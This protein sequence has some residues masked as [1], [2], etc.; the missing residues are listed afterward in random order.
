MKF[1]L[2]IQ[3][4]IQLFIISSSVVIY[5]AA[6]GYISLNARKMAYT[7]AIELTN[8]KVDRAAQQVKAILDAQFYS[9]QTLSHAFSIFEDYNNDEW[10][11]MIHEMYRKV[12]QNNPDIYAL[13]DSWELSAIDSTWD[14]SYGR[15]SH[16]LWREDGQLKESIE[17][18]SMDGDSKLYAETKSKLEPHINEPYLD[19]GAEGKTELLL[20]TSLNAPLIKEGKYAGVISYD[21]TLLQF[22][23]MVEEIKP[24]E[25]SYAF[26]VSNGG[27]ISGHPDKDLL[28][29]QIG[30]VFEEDNQHYNI[31]KKIATGEFFNY[32]SKDE[33]GTEWYFSYAPINVGETDTPWSIAISVPVETIMAKANQ[34]FIISLIVG[35]AG[36]LIISLIIFLISKNITNPISRI[37]NLL[38]RLAKGHIDETM[39]VK[40]KTSDEIAEMAEALN[41]SVDALIEKQQ[42]AQHIGQG[43]LNK[44]LDLLSEEDALGKSLLEMR[45]SLAKAREEEE[46]RKIEDD[47]R[48]WANEGLARFADILRQ[49]NDDL[50]ELAFQVIMNIVNYLEAN[51]GGIFIRNENEEEQDTFNLLA[52]Y[53]YNRRKYMQKSIHLGEGLVGTCAL[54]KQ[55]I[56]LTE[57]P[58][59]YI[60]ITSG[61]GEA[62]P[63]SLFIVPL[64]LE[65]QVL[66][67]LEIASFKE[68]EEHE[69]EFV[70][71]VAESIASTLNSV[72]VNLKTSELLE[73]SQQQAEEMAA[74]E[75][76]MRQNMEELQAT[77]EESTRKTAEMEGLIE[78]LNISS[79]VIEYDLDGYIQKVNENYLKLLEQPKEE[80]LGK[81]HSTGIEFSK[82]Q[83]RNYDKFWNDLRSGQVKRQST[84]IE[85]HGKKY[86]FAET[87]TPIRDAEGEIYKV[88]KISNNISD[89]Q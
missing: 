55:E 20:M 63:K 17:Y 30:E 7:D 77:Q 21:I 89:I 14:K 73:R 59:D 35:L 33:N 34:S 86:T 61:L 41:T 24:F 69:R 72:K 68:F 50:K 32:T 13:W 78:A 71:K 29:K 18:R 44:K 82:E 36:I 31:A 84:Q 15:L 39:R 42:F 8:S 76:E 19:A 81:H 67:V 52:T 87:Y 47:K 27:L 46:K 6:I 37:T 74:Q 56:Y 5:L 23:K 58:N 9:V 62:N 88:L 49:N 1:K 3:Q 75:E 66:G 45:D 60:R 11:A 65:D 64:K 57:I 28:N 53:A 85:V 16:V 54:E 79:Y 12:V 25:G 70:L 40:V 4:K 43:E 83:K 80:V 22:Q 2:K 26:M 10:Q 51:Q 38:Q 48:K